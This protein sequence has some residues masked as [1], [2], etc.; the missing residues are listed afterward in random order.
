MKKNLVLFKVYLMAGAFT[1]SGGMAMLPL[2]ERELCTK[3]KLINQE[4]LHEF[5]TLSQVFPG[6]IALTNACFVGKRIN[7]K[8]GMF[9]AGLGAILPAYVLMSIAT[10]L[11]DFLPKEGAVL[12]A[13]TAIRATSASFLFL[14]A[15]TIARFNLKEKRLLLFSFIAFLLTVFNLL[16]APKLI[17][18]GAFCGVLFVQYKKGRV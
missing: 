12:S 11:Y 17:I 1:F 8:S 13:L 15:Y 10:I 3:R 6:V 9:F 7:G 14:A 16:S 18:A 4:E 2:V 5:T